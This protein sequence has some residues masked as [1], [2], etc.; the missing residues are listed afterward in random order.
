MDVPLTSEHFYNFTDRGRILRPLVRSESALNPWKSQG[1]ADSLLVPSGGMGRGTRNFIGG[2]RHNI[3][4]HHPDIRLDQGV[5]ARRPMRSL[6]SVKNLL[7]TDPFLLGESG[8]D[9]AD[10]LERIALGIIDRS[11]NPADSKTGPMPLS[12]EIPYNAKVDGVRKLPFIASLELNP[13]E[14][15]GTGRIGPIEP[16]RHHPFETP[17][18]PSVKKPH[19]RFWIVALDRLGEKNRIVFFDE[20]GEHRPALGIGAR[21]VVLVVQIEEVEQVESKRKTFG[22][23]LDPVLSFSLARHLERQ[24][25]PGGLVVGKRLPLHDRLGGRQMTPDGFDDFREHRR[26]PFKVA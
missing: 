8:T 9:S 20:R 21:G 6:R 3:R 10:R 22:G 19:D 2:H 1:I 7:Q 23:L 15:P 4:R 5:D 17:L 14:V 13:V 16:L 11:Q 24:K 18:D 12:N 26:G 25:T